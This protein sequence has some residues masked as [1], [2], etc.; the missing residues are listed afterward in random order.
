M[1]AHRRI[2]FG[3]GLLLAMLGST[4]VQA[5]PANRHTGTGLVH[6]AGVPQP[7]TVTWQWNSATSALHLTSGTSNLIYIA[8]CGTVTVDGVAQPVSYAPSGQFHGLQGR[9]LDCTLAATVVGPDATFV[10]DLHLVAFL[11]RPG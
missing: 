7:L 10:L 4:T 2:V 9:L 11:T 1:R 5:A 3:L 6:C 8:A